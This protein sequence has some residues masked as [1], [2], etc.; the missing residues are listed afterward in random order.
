MLMSLWMK[1]LFY[2]ISG[3]FK[4]LFLLLGLIIIEFFLYFVCN[5][6]QTFIISKT[7]KN[8]C[9]DFI[10]RFHLFLIFSHIENYTLG[11][12]ILVPQISKKKLKLFLWIK[13]FECYCDVKEG[14][15]VVLETQY[16]SIMISLR[17]FKEGI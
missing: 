9:F 17:E 12:I 4:S 3:E 10:N 8:V 7:I 1:I 13:C 16:P 11:G 15:E 14:A 5:I 6:T 2:V